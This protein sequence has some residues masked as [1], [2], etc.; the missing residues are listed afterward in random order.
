MIAEDCFSKYLTIIFE[1]NSM[2]SMNVD[3]VSEGIMSLRKTFDIECFL[4]DGLCAFD[5]A[6]C[7][8]VA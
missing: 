3:C 6:L 4:A 1:I 5:L 7:F 2:L 8:T